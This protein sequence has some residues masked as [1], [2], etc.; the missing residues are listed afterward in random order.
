MK[1]LA[2]KR[3]LTDNRKYRGE[4]ERDL[5]KA[6]DQLQKLLREARKVMPLKEAAVAAGIDYRHAKRLT[7]ERR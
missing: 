6:R 4:L 7:A 3:K 5:G 1:A 2:V